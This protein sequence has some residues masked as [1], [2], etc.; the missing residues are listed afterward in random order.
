MSS[1]DKM[2]A[3][4]LV[5]KALDNDDAKTANEIMRIINKSIMQEKENNIFSQQIEII[6]RKDEKY[7]RELI[8]EQKG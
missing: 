8:K 6:D 7:F 5:V 1:I 3:F 2:D 4:A